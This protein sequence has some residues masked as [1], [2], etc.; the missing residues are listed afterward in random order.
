MMRK[1]MVRCL[2]LILLCGCR[3][4]PTG[5]LVND[6]REY[7]WTLDTLLLDPVQYP[8]DPQILMESIWGTADNLYAV[9]HGWGSAGT[10][11][12]FDG[13]QWSNVRLGSF[14][15]GA[16][17]A[18]FDLDDIDGLGA[19]DIFAVGERWGPTIYGTSFIIHYD[20]KLWT[21]QQ[22]PGGNRLMSVWVNS[23]S[24]AWACGLNGTLLHYNG[25]EWRK[26][27]VSIAT[28]VGSFFYLS[29]IVRTP[30][31]EMFMLGSA[32]EV[33]PGNLLKWTYYFFRREAELWTLVDTF[34]REPWEELGKWGTEKLTVLPSGTMYSVDMYGVFQWNGERWINRYQYLYT[35]TAVFGT[36]D[37]NLF[38][39]GGHGLLAHYDGVN[40]F[41]YTHLA[42][43]NV[44]YAGGWA[45]ENQAFVLGWVDGWK[46]IVLRGR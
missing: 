16:I 9:G 32:Y 22:T 13:K 19:D 1:P 30:S 15:A 7:R 24:D 12:H 2:L 44:K 27:S 35:T 5:P 41:E 20:G 39:T 40:W 42:Q 18:P 45:D 46:T 3:H 6:P 26:D 4:S 34:V 14:E 23:P 38:V 33:M 28:A 11:W 8:G 29:S 21:E 37:D 25:T 43:Q 17:P 36:G 10:M 31:N